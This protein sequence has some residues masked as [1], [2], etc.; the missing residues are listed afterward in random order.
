MRRS[1]IRKNEVILSAAEFKQTT[2]KLERLVKT[3]EAMVVTIADLTKKK[4]VGNE[5]RTYST[6][7]KA[8]E[9]KYV[10]TAEWGT[11]LTGSIIDLRA[12]FTMGQGVKIVAAENTTEKEAV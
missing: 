10:G 8:I 6:A 2:A 4:Y 11:I 12:S 9:S 5:Y 7:V 3:R 1:K